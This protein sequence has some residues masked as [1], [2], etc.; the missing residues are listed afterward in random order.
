MDARPSNAAQRVL[1]RAKVWLL[2]LLLVLVSIIANSEWWTGIPREPRY[3][4]RRLSAWLND[5][6]HGSG[7]FHLNRDDFRIMGPGAVKWVT[8]AAGHGHV[9]P[10][11]DLYAGPPSTG[12]MHD[13][14][15]RLS[16]PRVDKYYN[17]RVAALRVLKG[18]GPDAAPA[19]PTLTRILADQKDAY[20]APFA[21]AVLTKIGS[22]AAPALDRAF[23]E[24]SPSLR[25]TVLNCM[26]ELYRAR[27]GGWSRG[28]PILSAAEEDWMEAFFLKA[29]KDPDANVRFR[30]ALG[31]AVS[32]LSLHVRPADDAAIPVLIESLGNPGF[33]NHSADATRALALFGPEAAA[34]V[35]DL[36]RLI[37]EPKPA[38]PAY[39]RSLIAST[40]GKIDV[41]EKRS[42]PRLQQL[43]ADPSPLVQQAAQKALDN[44]EGISTVVEDGAR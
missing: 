14:W 36:L 16:S 5:M 44:L 7:V 31:L 41:V 18:L 17:E 28:R 43:L 30:A 23:Q 33:I 19:I 6:A 20:Y 35:P 9:P 25:L 10:A 34:A 2:L 3:Q 37:D 26:D 15:E 40:L 12:A 4:G 29:L 24:G 11:R 21:V 39:S 13:L 42:K 38:N 32:R 22:A 8:W 1:P 27:A